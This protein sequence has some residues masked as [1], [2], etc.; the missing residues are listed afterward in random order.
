MCLCPFGHFITIKMTW[1]YCVA[2]FNTRLSWVNFGASNL[3]ITSL[4]DPASLSIFHENKKIITDA[5]PSGNNVYVYINI[6]WR[7]RF[8]ATKNKAIKFKKPTTSRCRPFQMYVNPSYRYLERKERNLCCGVRLW[9]KRFYFA[10]GDCESEG[11]GLKKT[12]TF[13][14]QFIKYKQHPI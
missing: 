5:D 8:L 3:F 7:F 10:F 6:Q 9:D 2:N 12:C 1:N 14:E 11:E 13:E 4:W